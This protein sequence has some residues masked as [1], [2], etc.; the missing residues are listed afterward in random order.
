[1][2]VQLVVE[3]VGPD[4]AAAYLAKNTHNRGIRPK[5]VDKYAAAMR[6]GEWTL[7]GEAIKFG[8][9]E[10]L[11]DGQH[12]LAAVVKSGV[13]ITTVVARGL[14]SETQDTLDHHTPRTLGDVLALHG[15]KS[16]SDLASAISHFWRVEQD[17][18]SQTDTPSPA[19]ALAVLE[20]HPGLRDSISTG[21]RV[22]TRIGLP[23]GMVAAYHYI[24]SCLDS[25]DAAVFFD[26]LCDGEDL[27]STSPIYAY[28][29]WSIRE[30]RSVGIAGRRPA[31]SRIQ[32]LLVKSWNAYRRGD[33]VK[34]LKWS[35]GGAHP[36]AFPKAA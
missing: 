29:E 31:R 5:V 32:A 36:E 15:E 33:E 17:M 6:R 9:D 21:S 7:N 2:A 24:F 3:K 22:N 11:L 25:E 4:E 20:V 28:R 26:R 18:E 16:A 23:R 19:Q 12:R 10:A 35:V 30:L 14:E 27:S 34:Q 13:E 1:M 8:E